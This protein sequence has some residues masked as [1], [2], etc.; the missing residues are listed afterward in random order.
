MT[1]RMCST[2]TVGA[3]VL[4]ALVASSLAGCEEDAQ[5]QQTRFQCAIVDKEGVERAVDCEDVNDGDGTANVGGF[6]YPVF[7]H[8]YPSTGGGYAPGQALP[9][10]SKRHRIGYKD[11]AGRQQWGLPPSGKIANNTVKT[12]VI[13]KGGTPVKGGAGGVGGKAGGGGS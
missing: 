13:G 1:R 11:A 2:R 4:A 3:G 9:A 5:E 12:N 10:D 8:S 6:F 7:I